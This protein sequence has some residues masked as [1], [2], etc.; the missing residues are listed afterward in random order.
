MGLFS[1]VGGLLN[2]LTGSSSAA[3]LS[4]KYSAALAAQNA[5][6]QKEFAQNAH[7][8]EVEDLKKAGLNPVLS[9]GGSGAS[10]SGGGGGTIGVT[11]GAG[12][13]SELMNSAKGLMS[14]AS[15]LGNLNADTKLKCAMTGKVPHEIKKL[16]SETNY[17]MKATEKLSSE[18]MLNSAKTLE[19][20]ATAQFQKERARGKT[21]HLNGEGHAGWG[22]F[23]GGGGFTYTY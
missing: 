16:D 22:G 14:L 5:A 17:N 9:A 10:A 1:G 3:S 21:I 18:I 19:A 11:A 12:G 20:K 6:Y 8:W 23:G 2:D 15:E 4:H 7:Q 13:F